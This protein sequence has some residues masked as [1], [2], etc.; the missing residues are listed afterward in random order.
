MAIMHANLLV[1][2]IA[3]GDKVA[4]TSYRIGGFN[5]TKLNGKMV[6][7]VMD[8]NAK[9]P[10]QVRVL[11]MVTR[12]LD[13]LVKAHFNGE[14]CIMVPTGTAPKCFQA[15]KLIKSKTLARD[16]TAPFMY[17]YPEWV[18]GIAAFAKALQRADKTM[19]VNFFNSKELY[20]MEL[21]GNVEGLYHGQQIS[22][23]NGINEELGVGLNA[24]QYVNGVH[25]VKVE[26]GYNGT[27]KYYVNR[28]VRTR[29]NGEGVSQFEQAIINAREVHAENAKHV[30]NIP[31]PKITQVA[32]NGYNF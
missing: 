31:A 30:P 19:T 13:Q 24:W 11:K 27:K 18:D 21:T 2:I 23:V 8:V 1:D 14:V 6:T 12:V 25:T 3:S 17:D 15:K 7:E 5:D 16:L 26:T 20:F 9:L 4:R 28:I 29:D 10:G 22:L 32:M